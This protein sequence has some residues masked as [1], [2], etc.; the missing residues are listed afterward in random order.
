MAR[1]EIKTDWLGNKY[2]QH[3]D[4]NGNEIGRSEEKTDW[5]GDNYIQH[6]DNNGTETGRSEY[7]T[8]WLG[9][10]Y[11][12]HYD[13]N[14]SK[15]GYSEE[16]EDWLGNE[17]TQHYDNEEND[18]GRTENKK[19]WLGNKYQE[20]EEAPSRNI[21]TNR[22]SRPNTS[23]SGGIEGFLIKM[24]GKENGTL[25]YRIG[26][27]G[28]FA[29]VAYFIFTIAIPLFIINTATIGLLWGLAKKENGKYLFLFSI[30][31]MI[32]LIVD[33]NNSWLTDVL[34]THA[35]FFKGKI[36][37][38]LYL[39]IATGFVS[40]YIL[41]RNYFN[42]KNAPA[43]GESEF[44]KRNLIIMGCL[45]I[46]GGLTV[47][48]QKYFETQ[49][50]Q[51]HQ[52]IVPTST[53]PEQLNTEEDNWEEGDGSMYNAVPP[54]SIGYVQTQG[55]SNLKLR[56]QPSEQAPV[57][58]NIPNG[59][60]VVILGYGDH[61]DEINGQRGKWCNVDFNGNIGWAWGG[62]IKTYSLNNS[63]SGLNFNILGTYNNKDK[64]NIVNL[65][66]NPNGRILKIIPIGENFYYIP[67][68]SDWY[69]VKTK[70]GLIG[71][72]KADRIQQISETNS[73]TGEYN[74]D[75]HGDIHA[76]IDDLAKAIEKNDKNTIAQMT[77]F[78]LPDEYGDNPG[79]QS[80]TTLG[81]KSASQFIEKF[82]KIFTPEIIRDIKAKK[83]RGFVNDS[84]PSPDIINEGEYLIEGNND[85]GMLGI[86]LVNGK[87]KIYA[88]KFYS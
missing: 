66:E 27:L 79:N 1:S 3:Y 65:R 72:I 18:I 45:I 60:A 40:T 5:A 17:Y 46:A 2:I 34:V 29:A 56:S 36:P 52:F 77:H 67:S 88:L 58:A 87:F 39:N 7:K 28:I 61:F 54:S 25:Y 37:I 35:A 80:P 85:I 62:F 16:K 55:A 59:T 63:E 75:K 49:N 74:F 11:T 21:D 6:Y 51:K 4:D 23:S 48:L 26:A 30:L 42:S 73:K 31:G 43:E 9:N 22:E 50:Q 33:Y 14:R 41:I 19:D 84:G 15:T 83:F 8:D 32:F 78:P 12:Q 24:F 57:I 47:G 76:F 64:D 38:L 44:S 82:N 68:N 81:C 86:K 53:N 10:Q 20:T 69:L 70:D 13:I 71:Y